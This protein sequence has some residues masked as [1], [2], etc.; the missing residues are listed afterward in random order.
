MGGQPMVRLPAVTDREHCMSSGLCSV[1]LAEGCSSL[2]SFPPTNTNKKAG[3]LSSS[4]EQFGFN[5]FQYTT[6]MSAVMVDDFS[7]CALPWNETI[8]G[9]S[10]PYRLSEQ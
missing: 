2:G 1:L 10:M 5:L 3:L 9:E 7:L 6:L 8:Q 4:L